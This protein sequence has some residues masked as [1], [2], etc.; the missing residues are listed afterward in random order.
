LMFSVDNSTIGQMLEL[1]FSAPGYDT[2][3]NKYTVDA[4]PHWE[5]S[6]IVIGRPVGSTVRLRLLTSTGVEISNKV[7]TIK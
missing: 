5:R 2:T 1:T 7:Q 4:T 3:V 6:V